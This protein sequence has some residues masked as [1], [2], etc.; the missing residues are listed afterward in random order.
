MNIVNPGLEREIFR[1]LQLTKM[2]KLLAKIER[3]F[4]LDYVS[5]AKI[6]MAN[7][8]D[9][10]KGVY[11]EE[12][13]FGLA[14]LYYKLKEPKI[15]LKILSGIQPLN[16]QKVPRVLDLKGMCFIRLNKL[17]EASENFEMCILID[18]K[19][20]NS[21]NNLGN[22]AM[23]RK[24]FDKSILYYNKSKESSKHLIS[25][26]NRLGNKATACFNLAMVCIMTDD[27]IGMLR[28]VLE[29]ELYITPNLVV[30]KSLISS[31]LAY[32][33]FKGKLIS[34]MITLEELLQIAMMGEEPSN[35]DL[36]AAEG[37][38]WTYQMF[39]PLT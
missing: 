19:H 27:R 23:H 39:S 14:D 34:Y 9:L 15:S 13:G 24:D 3:Q 5:E 2:R 36:E 6:N 1:R 30:Y 11:E 38:N 26:S 20:V 7:M 12:I 16:M 37:S 8:V 32:F 22:I 33:L 25:E 21:L 10:S 4:A 18:S 35:L 31:G 29:L 17:K 28:Q